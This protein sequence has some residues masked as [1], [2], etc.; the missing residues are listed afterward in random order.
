MCE[1]DY[2]FGMRMRKQKRL[3]LNRDI[4]Y[5]GV[6]STSDDHRV[7]S[8]HRALGSVRFSFVHSFARSNERLHCRTGR[9]TV[10]CD[11]ARSRQTVGPVQNRGDQR[12][13]RV[14]STGHRSENAWVPTVCR[15]TLV[16]VT[17]RS[18]GRDD[19]RSSGGEVL[20]DRVSAVEVSSCDATMSP[21]IEINNPAGR[22]GV[23]EGI[24][25]VLTMALIM[26]TRPCGGGGGGRVR[27]A[28]AD[29]ALA[30]DRS[31]DA[32]AAAAATVERATESRTDDTRDYVW[33][34]RRRVIARSDCCGWTSRV[35]VLLGRRRGA[36]TIINYVVCASSRYQSRVCATPCARSAAR[37]RATTPLPP[38]PRRQTP[39]PPRTVHR[40]RWFQFSDHA[41]QTVAETLRGPAAAA[42]WTSSRAWA[43]T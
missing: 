5:S 2:T 23:Y 41:A 31:I 3:A 32:L 30:D 16:A 42:A 8:F 38:F 4:R 27:A 33:R 14:S 15:S 36:A 26:C 18:M 19:G 13:G 22:A 11:E 20:D 9:I 24:K 17:R 37:R 40:S 10:R 35:R 43:H 29:V 28:A 25:G 7:I 1:I 6:Y 12:N 34:R 21:A 39:R